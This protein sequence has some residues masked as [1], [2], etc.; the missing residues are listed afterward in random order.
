MKKGKVILK[1]NEFSFTETCNI[2]NNI[3]TFNNNNTLYEFD[4]LNICLKKEDNNYQMLFDFQ[5]KT[6]KIFDKTINKELIIDLVINSLQ[7]FDNKIIISYQIQEEVFN[8]EL[9]FTEE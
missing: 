8:L 4:F 3:I 9:L 7:L 2:V 6:L 1:I 5:N